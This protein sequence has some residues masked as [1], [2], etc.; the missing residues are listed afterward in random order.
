MS[1][2][3]LLIG[4]TGTLWELVERVL[5]P[6]CPHYFLL[7]GA[8]VFTLPP[9]ISQV[10]SHL[11]GTESAILN[12]ESGDSES[13]DPNRAIP[14]SLQALIGCDSDGDSESI[15]RD[16]ILLRF[17]SILCF[18]LRNFWRFQARDSGN[19]AVR[20][21]RSVPLSFPQPSWRL[22]TNAVGGFGLWAW[23][24]WV[25]LPLHASVVSKD[26]F[27]PCRPPFGL[28]AR[29]GSGLM[30]SLDLL[31]LCECV[32][33]VLQLQCLC[34]KISKNENSIPTRTHPPK[35]KNKLTP[36]LSS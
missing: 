34:G 29:G 24:G 22:V 31:G 9:H 19:R 27:S 18:S 36:N 23:G 13:C 20:D 6:F 15:F 25:N 12:R 10:S 21:S 7:F 2:L 30:A 17:H 3:K 4:N 16:S 33:R 32:V 11:S 14:R 35:K 26:A 5:L 1:V 28:V 8:C